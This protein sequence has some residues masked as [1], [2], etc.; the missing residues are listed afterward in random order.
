MRYQR[1]FLVCFLLLLPSL[2]LYEGNTVRDASGIELNTIPTRDYPQQDG[3]NDERLFQYRSMWLEGY[4]IVNLSEIRSVVD[5]ARENNFN[6]LSPL[7]NG[8]YLGVFYDSRYF[9]KY[10]EVYWD[11]D[12]LMELIKEAH[13]YNI[14]VMPWFHTL[15]AYP[16]L[17]EHPEWMDRT[18]SGSST[19]SWMDPANPQVRQFL[20]NITSELFR[21]YPIDGIKLDTIRYGGSNL[22]YTDISIRKYYDEGWED[23]SDFRRNQITEVVS[24][25][26][27]TIMDLRPYTWVG[28]DIWHQ[29]S[30]WYSNVFQDSRRWASEG[31]IDFVTTMSYT[32]SGSSFEANL[33]DNLDNFAC[34]VVAGPYVFVPGNTAH[35]SVP[36]EEAGIEIM[37]N[38]TETTQMLGA[39]GTCH[40]AYKFLR[41]WPSYAKALREGPFKD[42]ALCPL[43]EQ[44][45]PVKQTVWEFDNDQDREGW[46]TTD[47][48]QFYPVDGLWSVSNTISP[49]FMSPDLDLTADGTNVVEIRAISQSGDGVLKVYWSPSRTEFQEARSLSV[50]I[51]EP[52]DWHLYSI[53]LDKDPEWTGV[54]RYIRIVFEFPEPTNITLDRIELTWMPYCIRSWGYLGPFYSGGKE[55]LLDRDFIGDETSQLPRIGDI[56]AGRQW[57]SYSMERDKID[58]QFALGQLK[59]VSTYSHV[60]IRSDLEGPMELRIGNS[61][62]SR[63]WLNGEI[64]FSHSSTRYA[65]P[66]QNI[67][68]VLIRKGIN[69]LLLKQA[70]YGDDHAFFVRFTLPGNITASGL[71]FFDEIP[72]LGKPVMDPMEGEWIGSDTIELRWE[73]PENSISLDHYEWSLDGSLYTFVET[74]GIILDTLDTGEHTFKIRCVDNLGF[75]GIEYSTILKVDTQ[76][77]VISIPETDGEIFTEGRITWRW[78]LEKAP[79]SGIG[80]Y[81]VSIRTWS[82]GNSSIEIIVKEHAVTACEFTLCE[83]IEDGNFYR[84]EVKAV[85]GSG[86]IF[87]PGPGKDVLVDLSSP[88]IPVG[89]EISLLMM[90]SRKYA[91]TWSPSFD[92]TNGG[93]DHYEVWCKAEGSEWTRYGVVSEP[94]VELERPLGKTIETK[95]RAVDRAG[96]L[97]PFSHVIRPENSVPMP[98]ISIPSHVQGSMPFRLST[99]GLTDMDGDILDHRWY[100]DKKLVSTHEEFYLSLPP[101]DHEVW[102]WVI[103]DLGADGSVKGMISVSEGAGPLGSISEWLH[104]TSIEEIEME[105]M[106]ITHYGN[107]T[108]IIHQEVSDNTINRGRTAFSD[109]LI[110]MIAI[111]LTLILLILF[112]GVAFNEVL[113]YDRVRYSRVEWEDEQG[114][115]SQDFINRIMLNPLL[116]REI[117]RRTG[118]PVKSLSSPLPRLRLSFSSRSGLPGKDR[119][120]K[121]DSRINEIDIISAEADDVIWEDLE[122]E[123]GFD[124]WE[125]EA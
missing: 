68:L 100:V 10:P 74:E 64:V 88:T 91:M 73:P 44:R 50:S 102:L 69:T 103:D 61:D 30:S 124:E 18:S 54:I 115:G 16:A 95:V 81:L 43:K 110:V 47:M 89:L 2:V 34:E 63:L 36:S 121:R 26:Y 12:P 78:E 92:S 31:I 21:N 28:A 117:D 17:R 22:G 122:E 29:Y 39:L 9:P 79:I 107:N 109:A 56:L 13:K 55:D 42:R 120:L 123:D 49:K 111:A 72:L 45:H 97:S 23:F 114:M 48:G 116:R 76:I 20:V 118:G 8:H 32:T 108:V 25:L 93:Q 85:S 60:Y 4:Q 75:R 94:Y 77:P 84:A 14:Q 86:M 70:V 59:D 35:G 33:K 53:H 71:E 6:C 62:G 7:I 15:Y 11:F 27:N 104:T 1:M 90:G 99:V 19:S 119:G 112:L 125:V 51:E 5:L 57:K 83:G 40:F 105:P 46:R 67:S 66:D 82:H 58:L 96:H 98:Y 38:Q 52:G 101:G 106:N 65:A 37:V 113:S 24:I 87:S 41:E 80:Y 3:G